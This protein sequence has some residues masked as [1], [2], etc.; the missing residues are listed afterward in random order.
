M[1]HAN[2]S[3]R[4]EVGMI[5]R[6]AQTGTPNVVA[7]AII[8]VTPLAAAK[9]LSQSQYALWALASTVATIGLAV[10]FG[11]P[12]VV[13]SDSALGNIRRVRFAQACLLTT[14][15]SVL[16]SIIAA[17]AWL[18]TPVSRGLPLAG[19]PGALLLLTVG[20]STAARGVLVV[21]LSLLLAQGR[22]VRR[23]Q[24]LFLQAIAQSAIVIL[25]LQYW[26]SPFVLSVSGVASSAVAIWIGWPTSRRLIIKGRLGR[27]GEV[28]L[29]LYA[30]SRSSV[31][32]L[33]LGLTQL[34]RWALALIATPGFL[35]T[36]DVT[37]RLASI[38][39]F[40]ALAV[41]SMLVVEG[42]QASSNRLDLKRRLNKANRI[43]GTLVATGSA[44]VLALSLLLAKSSAVS[45]ASPVLLGGML[46]W[47]GVN[48]MTAP[49]TLMA[50][51]ARLPHLELYY[52][53][54]CFLLTLGAWGIGIAMHR[55]LV[56]VVM[57]GVVLAL[58]SIV[59]LATAGSRLL[60]SVERS[61]T[62]P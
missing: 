35:A 59:F 20:I 34:D 11:A 30:W 8:L 23:G 9:L 60:N 3:V 48:A 44:G 31:S 57:G 47:Y 40:G 51:G 15:G 1:M 25:L 28:S 10:D 16:V 50:V 36:Y 17:L 52:L 27:R 19:F 61:S 56:A 53:V 33:S 4:S 2:A 24:L 18:T 22:F 58:S 49:V 43:L 54:P 55:P 12:G 7:S 42:A 21:Q 14:A 45:L 46:I 41:S 38:P 62:S 29:K 32:L 37:A 5:R 26:R 6:L 39:R 13:I